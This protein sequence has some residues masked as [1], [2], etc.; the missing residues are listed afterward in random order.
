ME[1]TKKCCD[2]GTYKHTIPIIINNRVRDIDWC[3]A[4][5]VKAL[6]TAGITT[7]ASCCGHGKRFANIALI[8]GREILIC[9]D[10]DMARKAERAI[11]EHDDLLLAHE[12]AI[13]YF[14][15]ELFKRKQ[16]AAKI[17]KLLEV[18]KMLDYEVRNHHQLGG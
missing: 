1:K 5:I 8:D 12:I 17:N 9:P 16:H 2:V 18:V 7:I 11:S 4:P 3:I 14:K 15:A 10:F 6:N 13:N